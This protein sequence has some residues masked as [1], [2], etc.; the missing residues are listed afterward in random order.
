MQNVS[1]ISTQGG[2]DSRSGAARRGLR[3]SLS[4]KLGLLIAVILCIGIGTMLLVQLKL[5]RE[6]ALEEFR[7][8]NIQVISLVAQ[9][10]SGALRWNKPETITPT[11]E[12]VA[13]FDGS[14]LAN[15]VVFNAE[16]KPVVSFGSKRFAHHE[17]LPQ[18]LTAEREQ[19]LKAGEVQDF[20]DGED[21]YIILAPVLAGKDKEYVGTLAVALSLEVLNATVAESMRHGL[22]L[23]GG[24]LAALLI[25]L[26]AGTQILVSRPLRRLT[27]AISD[28]MAG[29]LDIA[30]PSL[31]RRDEVGD[32]ARS[33]D[34]FKG[35]IAQNQDL[36]R[37]RGEAQ[38]QQQ[39]ERE[40]AEAERQRQEQELD[41]SVAKILEA[42][43]G[44]DLGNR[45][46]TAQLEGA[47][48]RIGGGIN[49]LLD[50]T[51][52][53]LQQ[54]S[55]MLAAMADGDLSQRIKGDFAGIFAQIQ[56]N[57]NGTAEKL[58]SIAG[59][60]I[61]ASRTVRDASAEISTG[62]QD[63]ASRTESQAASI[64]ET[65]ASMHEITATV[66]QNADNAQ[67]A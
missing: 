57:A 4:Q 37:E 18:A 51:D 60:L 30:V 44:G 42:A 34:V 47:A 16:R 33:L 20:S 3:L 23:S 35:Q 14:A 12:S 48:Q 1:S 10:I 56:A 19:A 27:A 9:Q 59:R 40:R 21:H 22:L 11:L 28:L 7:S 64:E 15:A 65:A 54:I 45:I 13:A 6:A 26:V 25:A 39:A 67:A 49:R 41:R 50:I 62:S 38:A 53:S 24:L 32:I 43:I 58:T 8:S 52:R 36:Q 46:D 5:R 31:A 63:L 17:E 66:K 29:R 2:T 61:Q 55:R